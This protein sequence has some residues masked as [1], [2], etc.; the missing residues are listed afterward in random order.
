[1]PELGTLLRNYG[2]E[3]QAYL[4]RDNAKTQEEQNLAALEER[5][6]FARQAVRNNPLMALSLL[7]GAPLDET[8]KTLGLRGGRSNMGIM[9]S[10]GA[11]YTG[12]GEGLGDYLSRLLS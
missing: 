7:F 9:P 12:I 2:N 10:T 1:M 4:D 11:A 3:E 6:A 5:R 8:A